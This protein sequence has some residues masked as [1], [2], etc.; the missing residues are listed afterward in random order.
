MSKPTKGILGVILGKASI[1]ASWSASRVRALTRR[2][3]AFNL[4]KAPSIGEKSGE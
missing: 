3:M 4:E 1:I 2:N